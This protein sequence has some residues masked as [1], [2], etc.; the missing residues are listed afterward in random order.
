MVD[1]SKW[2]NLD[3]DD[4]EE[5]QPRRPRVTRLDGPSTITIG[6][7]PAEVKP[8]KAEPA[9]A[10]AHRRSGLDYSRWDAL[11]VD[12]DDGDDEE[13]EDDCADMESEALDSGEQ[14][15]LREVLA[16]QQAEN[17][18]TKGAAAASTPSVPVESK[19]SAF[20]A[21]HMKLTRNGAA[22]DRYLWRQT[23]AEVEISVFLP[24]RMGARNLQPVL[25]DSDPL[26][27][28]TQALVIRSTVSSASPLFEASLAYPV[29]QPEEL[30]D[31]QWE[32]TDFEP[33]ELGG[34]R[35]L[36]VT[37]QKQM[38]PGVIVWW[39]RAMGDESKV[40]T[41][42]F[43]D[44]KRAGKAT[45]QQTAWQ[46]AQ[47]LFRQKVEERGLPHTLALGADDDVEPVEESHES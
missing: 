43:P 29:T 5:D 18:A 33:P 17:A 16:A 35:V 47:R 11:E 13:D 1:Y 6:P 10:P 7:N 15:R 14:A 41:T 27:G 45:E 44:R 19:V 4:E 31:L 25:R 24:A 23:E 36:R 8:A 26:A 30:E 34:R 38:P 2:D 40:D 20:E 42:A 22:R 21:L 46:E 12:E 28:T 3:V 9:V 32:V 37:L 39:E